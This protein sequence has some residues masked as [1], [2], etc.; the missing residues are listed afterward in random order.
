LLNLE[1]MERSGAGGARV[2][3]RELETTNLSVEEATDR[4][5]RFLR[6]SLGF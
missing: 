3:C 1:R 6:E 4:V 2:V 5:L